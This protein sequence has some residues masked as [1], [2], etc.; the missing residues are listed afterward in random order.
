MK[1]ISRFSKQFFL[2]SYPLL[3]ELLLPVLK[4][5]LGSLRLGAVDGERRHGQLVITTL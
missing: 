2:R 1:D 3:K 5:Q 4:Y